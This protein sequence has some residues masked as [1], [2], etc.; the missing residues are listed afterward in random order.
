MP[1]DSNGNYS[2]PPGYLAEVGETIQP[3][4]HNPPLEDIRDALTARLMRSGAAPMAGPLK[5]TDG[6]VGAPAVIF[7][8]AQTTGFYKTA[9]GVGLAISGSLIAEWKSTGL[10]IGGRV[11]FVTETLLADK[12][13]TLRKLYKPSGPSKLLGTNSNAA[14]TITG[15]ANNGS[16]LIRLSVADSSTFATG[17]KKTVFDVLGTTEANGTWTITVV[18]ATHIDLQGSTFTNAWTSG[19][20]IGG[21]VDELGLGAG[22]QLTGS[23]LSAS[24][25]PEGT[26]RKLAVDVLTNTTLSVTADAVVMSDGTSTLTRP[27]NSTGVN[28]GTNGGVDAL[29]GSLTIASGTMY[30]LWA[31]GKADGTTKVLVNTSDTAVTFPTGYTFKALI[32]HVRTVSGSANLMGTKQRG[33]KVRYIVGL[34]QTTTGLVLI[35]GAS[36]SIS[37]PTWTAVSLSGLIPAAAV[38]VVVSV[39]NNGQANGIALVA[40]SNSYGS[41]TSSNPPPIV[42]GASSSPAIQGYVA[43]ISEILLESMN[44]YYAATAGSMMLLG[45]EEP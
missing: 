36:G 10:E 13:V 5:L 26:T 30:S 24:L 38:S 4:Q 16:G 15:A 11:D 20:T 40:P 43:A 34:A 27:I 31:I 23:T 19:G 1:S 17:Q 3:S 18:D 44:L 41:P 28:L 42:A 12:A 21:G 6:T 39:T 22:L 14:L 37:T 2:L 7:N 33:K 8:S 35:T 25:S 9:T 45:W 32:G 29:Q